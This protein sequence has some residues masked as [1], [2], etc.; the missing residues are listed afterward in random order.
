M[1]GIMEDT[2]LRID[3]CF[4]TCTAPLKTR[5]SFRFVGDKVHQG[6]WGKSWRSRNHP[7]RR[8]T[9]GEV[10]QFFSGMVEREWTEYRLGTLYECV[11]KGS[12]K[13]FTS[14]TV[15]RG[16]LSQ[17]PRPIVKKVEIKG[18]S[19]SRDPVSRKSVSKVR[20]QPVVSTFRRF[21]SPMLSFERSPGNFHLLFKYLLTP[22]HL[23]VT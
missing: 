4:Q 11:G 16:V 1:E 2:Q 7:Q 19:S 12:Y 18:L 13:T 8:T 6:H 15:V 3:L 23:S 20:T 9:P 10:R 5:S 14:D 17:S 21:V 22:T